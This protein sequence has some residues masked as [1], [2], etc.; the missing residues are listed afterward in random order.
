MRLAL[1]AL[2]ASTLM[3]GA[4]R[5]IELWRSGERSLEWSGSVR[6]LAIT[7]NGTDARKFAEAQFAAGPRCFL[8]A[9][10][11]EC[12]AFRDQGDRD[13]F[14]SLTR[15]RQHLDLQWDHGFSA[16]LAYDHEWRFGN[17]DRFPGSLGTRADTF[18]GLEDEI[19]LFGL[20]GD[21]DHRRWRHLLYRA[22]LRY[23]TSR[24]QFTAGRQRIPWGVG[25][26][27]NPIDRFNPIGPLAI[28]GDQSAGID[29]V[30][31][32][33]LF[34][35]FS[36][37]QFVYAPGT[38]HEDA[39][40]ATRYQGVVRDVDVGVMAGIFQQARTAGFDLAGNL[41][42][43][44]WRVEAVFTD[45]EQ[46]AWKLGDLRPE[47][48]EPFWQLVVSLDH[49][50]DIGHGIYALVEHFYD[51]NALGFGDGDAGTLLPFFGNSERAP[52]GVRGPGPFA[53]PISSARFGGSGVIS[54][55]RHQTGLQLGTD[56]NPAIRGN[57]LVIYDWNGDSAAIFPSLAFTGLNAVE[58]TVGGQLFS[59]KR[60]SQY[61]G[62]QALAYVLVEYFF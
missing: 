59:G 47:E 5:P 42:D 41:G 39:R 43:S 45:P 21:G 1:V 23:E 6:E 2:V 10:F 55:A 22:Y 52:A 32:R 9:T 36:Q 12:P 19:H 57:L 44:A 61:G 24:F 53:A 4:A 18:L 40:Y 37:L 46:R 62:Q 54:N 16:V 26:L 8:A 28:E 17:L 33:L 35:G 38:R 7:T 25:R 15:V 50:F 13:V 3:A 56:L 58:V 30:D 49:N 34:D 51:G 11:A 14:E 29:A 60:R 20:E 31:F 48:P 27:W